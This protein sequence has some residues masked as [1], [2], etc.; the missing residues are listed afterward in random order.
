MGFYAV[1]L[2]ADHVEVREK[3]NC[4]LSFL[5]PRALARLYFLANGPRSGLR[6][7]LSALPCARF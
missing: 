2:V 3:K 4:L 5:C 1:Y 7:P 6:L